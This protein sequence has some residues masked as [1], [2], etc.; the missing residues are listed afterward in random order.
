MRAMNTA[1]APDRKWNERGNDPSPALP[2]A[3]LMQQLR[4]H[5]QLLSSIVDNLTEAV[6]RTGPDHALIFANRAYLSLSGY[7][8]LEEMQRTPRETLYANPK[9][10]ARLLT[11]LATE[12]AF[13][14]EEIEY[15]NRH[16]KRWWG[17]TNSVAIR[18][19]ASG[20][21]LYHVGSVKDISKRKIAEAELRQLNATLEKR[22]AD[23]TAELAASEARLR[24]LLEHAPEAIVVLDGTTGQFLSGN[25]HACRLY[26]RKA[27][28]LSRLAPLDVSPSFQADGRPS[29]Q[30]AREKMAEALAGGV[31]VFEWLHRHSTGRLIPTEVR[32]V[33]LPGEKAML[34]ASIIDNSERKRREKIQQATYQI[35]EAVHVAQDL[36]NLFQQIHGIVKGLMPARNFY[37][38]L[39]DPARQMLDFAYRVDEK[40]DCPE[41]TPQH[42][43]LT[44][45]VL[46]TARSFLVCRKDV[47]LKNGEQSGVIFDGTDAVPYV[48]CGT[49]PAQWLG[50]PMLARGIA[51]GVLEVFDYTDEHAY[52]EEETQLL[53]FIATQTALAIERKRADQAVRESEEKFRALFE[54]S[55]AGVMLHDEQRYLEVNTA[56]LRMFGYERVEDLIGKS[57]ATTSPPKQPDGQSSDVAARKYISEC[58]ANGS[59]RFDWVARTSGGADLPVEVILTRVEWG[60][61]QIIQAVVNDIS[62]R[63]QVEAELLKSLA[64][65]KE[66]SALKSNFVSMVSHEFR[67]PLG[68]IMSSAEILDSYLEKLGREE[69]TSHLDSIRKNSRRMADLMEEVLVLSRFDAGRM[70]FT[71][72]P[73]DL[74]AFLRRVADEVLS[75][76]NRVCPIN[77]VLQGS[78]GE[79]RADERLLRHIFTNLLSNAIKYSSPGI[80]V[81]LEAQAEA[82]EW[83]CRVADKG[84][85]IPEPDRQYLF[86]AFHRGQNVGQ[87]HGTGLGLVIVKRCVELHGGTI[88]IESK[89]GE[90]ST[91]IVRW[92]CEPCVQKS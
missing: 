14:N 24:T 66:L 77:L 86:H 57:P 18:D 74:K 6:Y 51:M 36:D 53:S 84:I 43:G 91:A 69:R 41:A 62:K 2:D 49:P 72:A 23:R 25:E 1:T 85:G 88:S 73:V 75:A 9:D 65:E 33:R 12:D 17:V 58:M 87:R 8:S 80:P 79:A 10:R 68:I 52:G 28:E 3:V 15:I 40:D 47:V 76:T 78:V 83:V 70:D 63:K 55:S 45:H 35:S 38:S 44:G 56:S 21:L 16:G 89:V 71:P 50:A 39:H 59:A 82:R 7:E 90:G 11:L 92:P 29:L 32:L 5:E 37:I 34:R 27:D 42:A 64:R 20:Q 60:G 22:V 61:K 31:P 67:T 13:H 26:G 48:E 19:P 4:A 81:S 30:V 46:R 54:A